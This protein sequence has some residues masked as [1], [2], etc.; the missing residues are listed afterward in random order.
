MTTSVIINLKAGAL[1]VWITFDPDNAGPYKCESYGMHYINNV[2]DGE[3]IITF[4]DLI[5]CVI[6]KTINV[7]AP[8]L[9]DS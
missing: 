3:Y 7:V 4:T 1:P 9:E 2:P 8:D 6:T 5:D